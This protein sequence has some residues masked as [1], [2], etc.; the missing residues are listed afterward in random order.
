RDLQPP[1]IICPADVSVP[2]DSGT[3]VA[4]NVTLGT[5]TVSDNCS[6]AGVTNNAPLIYPLGTNLVTWTV[7]DAGGNTNTCEQRVIV[8][9]SLPPQ[10]ACPP[11]VT[12]NAN[13]GL[14]FATGVNL[15]TPTLTSS[16]CGGVVLSSNAP[17]QFS[18]GTNVVTWTA[19]DQC[20]KSGF[21]Q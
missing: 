11:T 15:G 7:I 16:G 8:T 4:T 21:C 10:I 6:I 13:N 17:T 19:T 18:L 2:P 3:N 20:G 12:V 5:P 1:T 14:C 9:S